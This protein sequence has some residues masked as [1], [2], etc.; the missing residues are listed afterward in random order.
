M[1]VGLLG[2]GHWATSVHGVG[3]AAHPD[4]S[5]VGVWGRDPDKTRAAAAT[6]G[7]RAYDDLDRLLSDVEAVSIALPPGIQAE[8]AGRAA[9][10]GCHLLLEKPIALTVAAATRLADEVQERGLASVVFLTRRFD[11]QT[12]AFIDNAVRANDWYG[13]RVIHCSSIVGP[14]NPYAGSA[15]RHSQGG[16]WDVGPHALAL[17]LPVLGPVARVT[18]VAGPFQTHHVTLEHVN[19]AVS[20]LTLSVHTPTAAVEWSA[21]LLGPNGVVTVPRSDGQPAVDAYQ[22]AIGRLIRSAGGSG[23]DPLD[24]RA[25]VPTVAVLAAAEQSAAGRRAVDL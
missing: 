24:A 17:V 21:S 5:F 22:V 3:L 4:V 8:L 23:P 25:S 12:Q 16:L 11:P 20:A 9:A 15:W 7:V 10:H 14:D 18:A 13:A 2:T 19:S 6:F 1:R